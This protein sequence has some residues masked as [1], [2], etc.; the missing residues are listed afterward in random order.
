[1]IEKELKMKIVSVIAVSALT[2]TF[3]ACG[4]RIEVPSTTVGMVLGSLSDQ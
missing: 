1:M 3:T 4:E 2:P